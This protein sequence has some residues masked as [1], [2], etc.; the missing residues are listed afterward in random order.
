MS[1][2]LPQRR[3]AARPNLRIDLRG[4]GHVD[5]ARMG[6]RKKVRAQVLQKLKFL[7]EL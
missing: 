3:H 4:A 2:R 5:T 7:D 1:A 6:K